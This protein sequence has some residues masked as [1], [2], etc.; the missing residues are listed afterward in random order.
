MNEVKLNSPKTEGGAKNIIIIVLIG[1][2]VIL[3]GFFY[4]GGK[5]IDTV[6]DK[7]TEQ[8]E[9]SDIAPV[10]NKVV[11]PTKTYTNTVDTRVPGVPEVAGTNAMQ[12]T[13]TDSGFVP[14]VLEVVAGNSVHFVNKSSKPMWV[15]SEFHPTAGDQRYP[16]FNQGKSISTGGEY[17]FLFT[18]VGV[19]G[20]KNLN[21]V[22]HL[23]A[24]SV[25]S[26]TVN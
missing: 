23:G 10:T 8:E 5:P 12:V 19:W 9:V 13:Y 3:F 15:T 24:I 16:E 2:V 11:V 14:P 17:V 21:E 18:K 25:I 7:V 22:G 26:Q 1:F 20:Y 6:N 4:F